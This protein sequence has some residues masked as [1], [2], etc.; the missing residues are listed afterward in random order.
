[1]AAAR[2]A[3]HPRRL[4]VRRWPR[5]RA[6]QQRDT[7]RQ[8]HQKRRDCRVSPLPPKLH[9]A[10]QRLSS[11][12]TLH[13]LALIIIETPRH[14]KVSR[15]WKVLSPARLEVL[16]IKR[17]VSPVAVHY[18]R[19]VVFRFGNRDLAHETVNVTRASPCDPSLYVQLAG[20]VSREHRVRI[21]WKELQQISH[22]S[23]RESNRN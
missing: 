10:A 13:D 4:R 1:R 9:R 23:H 15:I 11:P 20:V 14:K 5:R 6:Q 8:A 17:Q 2:L 21:I 19:D 7:A 18:F 16:S 3:R 22:V 12:S